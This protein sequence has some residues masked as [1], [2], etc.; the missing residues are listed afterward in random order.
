MFNATSVQVSIGVTDGS[1]L[2]CAGIVPAGSADG[3]KG[4]VQ[5]GYYRLL[6][7]T[8]VRAYRDASR[9]TGPYVAWPSSQLTGFTAKSGL[10]TLLLESAP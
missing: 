6:P 5:I 7:A 10:L 1:T 2:Y 9:C 3:A 4:F 8:E